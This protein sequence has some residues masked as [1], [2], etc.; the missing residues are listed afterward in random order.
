M[1]GF[2]FG[3]GARNELELTFRSNFTDKKVVRKD[4]DCD[5][6]RSILVAKC[7]GSYVPPL[8]PSH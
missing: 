3:I 7:A 8:Q 1:G 5:W 4:E 2:I 6:L